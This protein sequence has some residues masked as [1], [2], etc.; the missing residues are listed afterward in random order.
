MIKSKNE[1]RW[2]GLIFKNIQVKCKFYICDIYKY[3]MKKILDQK[4]IVLYLFAYTS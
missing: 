4:I 1:E 2:A 3:H